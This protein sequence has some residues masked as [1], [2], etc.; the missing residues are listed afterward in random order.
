M[1][2]KIY[3]PLLSMFLTIIHFS[4]FQK[5]NTLHLFHPPNVW[6]LV[7]P[8]PFLPLIRF[9][10][11]PINTPLDIEVDTSG[12][13]ITVFSPEYFVHNGRAINLV[14]FIVQPVWACCS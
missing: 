2:E 12:K 9:L 1:M 7:S 4:A 13:V 14:N 3:A 11:Y 8:F 5:I 6:Q 10:F